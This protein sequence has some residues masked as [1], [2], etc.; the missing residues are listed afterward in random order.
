MSTIGP[1]NYGICSREGKGDES[2]TK[3]CA[4]IKLTADTI[5]QWDKKHLISKLDGR[6]QPHLF[7]LAATQQKKKTNE[8]TNSASKQFIPEPRVLLALCQL[9]GEKITGGHS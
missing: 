5:T 2:G 7:S 8:R 3:V 4:S 6:D 1:V 9:S